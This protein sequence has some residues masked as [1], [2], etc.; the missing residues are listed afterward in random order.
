M[1]NV[2]GLGRSVTVVHLSHLDVMG[3]LGTLHFR[4]R[5]YRVLFFVLFF[6]SVWYIK[7]KWLIA[8]TFTREKNTNWPFFHLLFLKNANAITFIVVYIFNNGRCEI[9]SF[10]VESQFLNVSLSFFSCFFFNFAVG[11]FF[12]L[13]TSAEI[14]LYNYYTDIFCLFYEPAFPLISLYGDVTI[15][16][17]YICAMQYKR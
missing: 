12:S 5:F 4:L 8:V 6:Y 11:F 10:N 14:W 17:P 1:N 3:F 7:K 16:I 15:V 2:H 13:T 9:V